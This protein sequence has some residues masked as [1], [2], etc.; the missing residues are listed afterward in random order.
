MWG[1]AQVTEVFT[2]NNLCCILVTLIIGKICFLSGAYK[3]ERYVLYVQNLFKQ[4]MLWGLL[5]CARK[6][7][8]E[9]IAILTNMHISNAYALKLLTIFCCIVEQLCLC[10]LSSINIPRKSYTN[11]SPRT[12]LLF[13]PF[14]TLY[15]AS[16]SPRNWG[17]KRTINLVK[18]L[19]NNGKG[20]IDLF[21]AFGK[22]APKVSGLQK[23]AT[24]KSELI[25]KAIHKQSFIRFTFFYW[26]FGKLWSFDT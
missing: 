14:L 23:T 26:I 19:K 1:D 12:K 11:H 8:V 3:T 21:T 5:T 10:Y 22:E 15:K 13:W 17:T 25:A 4:Q 16:V 6:I 9:V 24:E 20:D 2:R 18:N 7:S